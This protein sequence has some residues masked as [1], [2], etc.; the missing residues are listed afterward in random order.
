MLRTSSSFKRSIDKITQSKCFEKKIQGIVTFMTSSF[1]HHVTRRL[2]SRGV[3]N[4][5]HHDDDVDQS[6]EKYLFS[7]GYKDP[8]IQKGMIHALKAAFGN[9]I[10]VSN[11]KSLGKEGEKQTKT[12]KNMQIIYDQIRM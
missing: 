5:N 7:L 12:E 6:T 11:L 2:L 8:K 9:N 3:N 10:S 1:Q 4:E